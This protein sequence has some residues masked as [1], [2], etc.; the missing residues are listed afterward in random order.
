MGRKSWL[1]GCRLPVAGCWLKSPRRLALLTTDNPHQLLNGDLALQCLPE[2]HPIADQ[3]VHRMAESG[4]AILLVEEMAGP[5]EPVPAQRHADQPPGIAGCD[6]DGDPRD[7]QPRADEVQA[8][9][10]AIGVL[11]EVVRIELAEAGEVRR[12]GGHVRYTRPFALSPSTTS[13]QATL[14]KRASSK[15]LPFFGPAGLR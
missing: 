2:H 11:A 8:P 13:G 12:H 1:A 6:R 7:H 4:R 3:A 10:A 9:A 5:G 14:A 15:R